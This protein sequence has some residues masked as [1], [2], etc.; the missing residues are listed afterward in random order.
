MAMLG[1][2]R[3]YGS[4]NNP[5]SWEPIGKGLIDDW[6]LWGAFSRM[7]QSM[8]P[9]SLLLLRQLPITIRSQHSLSIRTQKN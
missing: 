7:P 4:L 9:Y 5:A 3:G 1:E 2:R 6:E 8:H